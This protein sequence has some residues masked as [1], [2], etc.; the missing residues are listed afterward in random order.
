MHMK[1]RLLLAVPLALALSGGAFANDASDKSGDPA[2][3]KL[4][5]SL[6]NINGFEVLDARAGDDGT[7]CITYQV[8]NDRNGMSKSHAV[9]QGD[10]VLHE[11]TGN[12]RFAKAWNSKCVASR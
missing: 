11:T 12:T 9:V 3:E 7:T 10:K 2:V 1:N 8:T 4:K 6:T 5:S